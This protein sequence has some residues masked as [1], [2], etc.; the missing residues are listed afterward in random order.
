VRGCPDG[1]TRSTPAKV[2]VMFKPFNTLN[3]VVLIPFLYLVLTVV[4][5]QGRIFGQPTQLT[6][7]QTRMLTNV[8]T[9]ATYTILASDCGKL[10]SFSNAGAVAVTLPQVGQT[11]LASGCWMDIQNLGPGT[12]TITPVTS[13][14][15]SAASLQLAGNQGIRLVSTG[16]AYLTQRGQGSAASGT[17]TNTS[18]TM[19]SGA[20]VIG[21][22]G[23][24]IK[25][26]VSAATMDNNGNLSLPGKLTT[27]TACNGCAG[28]VDLVQGTDPGPGQAANS[29][30]LFAPTSIASSFRWKVPAADAPGAIVSDGAGNPGT[31]SITPVANTAT[32]NAIVQTGAS[33]LLS[34]GF[35]GNR[36][37][38]AYVFDGGGAPLSGAVDACQDVPFAATI[39]GVTLLSDVPGSG[40]VDV[41][42]VAYG[43][44][45]GPSSAATITASDTP[46]LSSAV[47]Y[48][49]TTLTG[50]TTAVAANSVLCFHLTSPATSTWIT[51]DLYGTV[52]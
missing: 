12:V 49:D 45:T 11:G 20:I 23:T 30:S 29:F 34:P 35:Y 17:V 9:G 52:Q 42:T 2:N 7:G 44:Y 43:G 47:K 38:A 33:G 41:R 26:P 3:K 6:G 51:V 28:A 10:I 4:L 13:S 50:W 19:T 14:I 48:Q 15:D 16:T 46:A 32:A 18:G 40:T 27:D 5:P 31:L 25:T 39:T 8:Q 36:R 22:G 1:F 24:D 37:I 21:N